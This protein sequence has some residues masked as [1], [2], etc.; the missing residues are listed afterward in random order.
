MTLGSI[1]AKI[2]ASRTELLNLALHNVHIGSPGRACRAVCCGQT[3]GR[4]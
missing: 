3:Q 2:E 4:G 1:T